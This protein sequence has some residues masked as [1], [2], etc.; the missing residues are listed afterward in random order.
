MVS[1]LEYKR[2]Y[3][4]SRRGMLELDLILLPFLERCFKTLEP[5]L[6]KAYSDL[7]KEEDQDIYAWLVGR[8]VAPEPLRDIV[9]KI[10]EHNDK[11]A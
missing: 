6:Q 10:I 4:H 5:V 9:A 7:L 11:A 2:L 8:E 3:W 1:E